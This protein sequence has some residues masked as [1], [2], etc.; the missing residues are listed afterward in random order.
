MSKRLI[1]LAAMEK[2][3]K[4]AGAERVSDKSKLAL[5]N[6]MYGGSG[7]ESKEESMVLYKELERKTNI[8]KNLN[9]LQQAI[10]SSEN[11]VINKA[12]YD[13]DSLILPSLS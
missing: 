12:L 3:M 7:E 5:K 1:P 2:I 9:E 4:K 6:V 10:L 11:I 13:S 8:S